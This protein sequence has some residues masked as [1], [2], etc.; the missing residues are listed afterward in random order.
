M[1]M[2][3]KKCGYTIMCSCGFPQAE[4]GHEHDKGSRICKCE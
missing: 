1:I 3:C 2:D 4:E